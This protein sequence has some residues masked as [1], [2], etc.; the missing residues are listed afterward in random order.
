MVTSQCVQPTVRYMN[1]LT[2]DQRVSYLRKGGEERENHLSIPGLQTI[3]AACS[4]SIFDNLNSLPSPPCRSLW[5]G[6]DKF[7]DL[8]IRCIHH[9][10]TMLLFGLMFCLKNQLHSTAGKL[11][12]GC[13][14][15]FRDWFHQSK[16]LRKFYNSSTYVCI[17]QKIWCSLYF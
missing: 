3:I 12:G 6:D 15:G 17:K 10:I 11:K 4:F 9:D 7:M 14:S 16:V 8:T 13:K 1:L 5:S 2:P